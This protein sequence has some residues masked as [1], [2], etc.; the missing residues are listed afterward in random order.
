MNS[1][2]VQGEVLQKIIVVDAQGQRTEQRQPHP[3][4]DCVWTGG[5]SEDRYKGFAG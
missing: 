3:I 1:R 2:R 5:W 4:A